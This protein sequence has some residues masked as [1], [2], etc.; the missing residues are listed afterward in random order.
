VLVTAR[1]FRDLGASTGDAIGTVGEV[2]TTP[3]SPHGA[4]RLFLANANGDA[5]AGAP[6][7]AASAPPLADEPR[8]PHESNGSLFPHD[9]NAALLP[10]VAPEPDVAPDSQSARLTLVPHDP[11]N[12][13]PHDPAKLQDRRDPHDPAARNPHDPHDPAAVATSSVPH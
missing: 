13:A 7:P 10:H 3:R 12:E 4:A 5:A 9:P 8:V 2:A 1:R 11:G 6:D